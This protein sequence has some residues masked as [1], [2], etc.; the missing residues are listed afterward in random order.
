MNLFYGCLKGSPYKW[1]DPVALSK[2][3]L[4]NDEV[5]TV[6]YFTA[7]LINSP[8]DPV[9]HIRQLQYLRALATLP[10]VTIHLGHYRRD[11]VRMPV[12]SPPPNTIEVIKT[13]EKGTD[14]SLGA[15]VMRDAY[16]QH[17]EMQLVITNDCDLEEPIR[18]VRKDVRMMVGIVNPHAGSRRTP[19]LAGDFYRSIRPSALAASQLPAALK[20]AAGPITKPLQW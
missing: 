20:D 16:L 13:E 18:L 3:L 6:R 15:H 10:E 1:L 5:K 9:R 12:A 4:P 2:A 17:C 8:Q 11:R 7:R 14:V 19:R